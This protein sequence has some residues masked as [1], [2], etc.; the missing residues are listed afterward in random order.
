MLLIRDKSV[1]YELTTSKSMS[2][3][4]CGIFMTSN[5]DILLSDG[6]S[7]DIK[8]MTKSVKIKPFLSVSPLLTRGIHVTNDNNIIVGVVEHGGTYTPPPY[9][10]HPPSIN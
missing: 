10:H 6:N 8:L 2:D 3:C 5:N 9:N 1:V 4:T 7:S